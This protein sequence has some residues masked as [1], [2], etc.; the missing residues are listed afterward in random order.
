MHRALVTLKKMLKIAWK[1]DLENYELLIY[2]LIGKTFYKLGN[3]E[4]ALLFHDKMVLKFYF[5]I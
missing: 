1:L 2:D 4:K 5:L 3:I